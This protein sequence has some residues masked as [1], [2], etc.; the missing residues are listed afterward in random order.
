MTAL[1]CF[2]CG[3]YCDEPFYHFTK[4]VTDLQYLS[5]H[6][7]CTIVRKCHL[8][9]MDSNLRYRLLLQSVVISHCPNPVRNK[10]SFSRLHLCTGK[11]LTA[12]SL[13]QQTAT[14][15]EPTKEEVTMEMDGCISDRVVSSTK[16][17]PSRSVKKRVVCFAKSDSELGSDEDG[18]EKGP[19]KRSFEKKANA[20]N[21]DEFLSPDAAPALTHLLGTRSKIARSYTSRAL[22]P[23]TNL[24]SWKKK[25]W[26]LQDQSSGKENWGSNHVNMVSLKIP[27]SKMATKPRAVSLSSEDNRKTFEQHYPRA[28]SAIKSHA[29]LFFKI[30]G[31]KA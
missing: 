23:V 15:V 20:T 7:L 11:P 25:S 26:P 8:S 19:K 30:T 10:P 5:S 2:E 18:E 1:W 16:K 3:F 29:D 21:K 13:Y 9:I 22:A 31:V 12:A 24:S 14:S 4:C 27:P 6:S 17:L 28:Y